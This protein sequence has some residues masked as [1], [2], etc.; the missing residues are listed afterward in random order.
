M[1]GIFCSFPR[2]ICPGIPVNDFRN[3]FNRRGPDKGGS[4][5]FHGI[6]FEA[7]VLWHQGPQLSSQPFEDNR[8]ILV[9]NGDLFMDEIQN[10]SDSSWFFK[11]LSKCSTSKDILEVLRKI[12][13][14]FC[15]IYYAKSTKT[16][17]FCRDYLGRNSLLLGMNSER[18]ILTSTGR[19]SSEY[20]L[21]ELPP[22]GLYA[23]HTGNEK[24][25]FQIT[26]WEEKM[27]QSEYFQKEENCLRTFLESFAID[28]KRNPNEYINPDCLQQCSWEFNYSFKDIF[29]KVPTEMH[30]ESLLREALPSVQDVVEILI[31]LLEKS[32]R[33][34]V[35]T[36]LKE[37]KNCLKSSEKVSCSHARIGILFSGGVDCTILTILA[38]KFI[39]NHATIDLLN[40][41]FEKKS[42]ACGEVDWNVPDRVSA[43][44]ALE[45]VKRICPNRSWNLIEV[46]VKEEEKIENLTKEISHL[47]HPRN[48]ILDES[49]GVALW[50]A[51]SGSTSCRVIL[52]GSGADELFGGYTRHQVAFKRGGEEELRRVLEEDLLRLPSRNLARDDR[53]I[54]D[55]GVTQRAPF[56]EEQI[57]QFVSQLQPLQRCFPPL[58]PGVGDKTL[59]RLCAYQLGL[60]E[61]AWRTKKALQF[62]SRVANSKQDANDVSIFLS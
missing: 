39:P 40:V 19:R 59:L 21:V 7:S 11:S 4:C 24:I 20:S 2:I 22:L 54:C 32:V 13:G 30:H 34:R 42:S 1:C 41:A 15:F 46:N 56:V 8:G 47:I 53:V 48:T 10:S 16:L 18:I 51:A 26:F 49:L 3:S 44:K 31:E 36:T 37:C 43:R 58:G 60:R 23:I 14:P 52:I 25:S 28:Y 6:I 12:R 62:G 29:A 38:D 5:I 27:I 33:D 35:T 17:F 9:F 57:V 45:E 50:F 61:T 55:H